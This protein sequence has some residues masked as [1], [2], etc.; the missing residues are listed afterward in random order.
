MQPML[1]IAASQKRQ[2]T[3]SKNVTQEIL[4]N[5]TKSGHLEKIT[6]LGVIRVCNQV[7]FQPAG[8]HVSLTLNG[9]CFAI[10]PLTDKMLPFPKFVASVCTAEAGK[11]ALNF[12]NTITGG[13]MSVATLKAFEAAFAAEILRI[14]GYFESGI[15]EIAAR[16]E[17]FEAAGIIEEFGLKNE[18]LETFLYNNLKK[19][20]SDHPW[21]CVVNPFWELSELYVDNRAAAVGE[22]SLKGRKLFWGVKQ[23]PRWQIT[24]LNKFMSVPYLSLYMND[25]VRKLIIR[26]VFF[27][28]MQQPI[29]A[30]IVQSIG[31][32]VKRLGGQLPEALPKRQRL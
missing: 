11:Y 16:L 5:L 4:A 8:G 25:D 31:N 24:V 12:Y 32:T 20:P 13:Y 3:Y 18:Q 10:V 1:P 19:L 29:E 15:S 23:Y 30:V 9:T 17:K 22:D 6:M 14:G 26:R 2:A 27:L 7:N 21:L 28:S